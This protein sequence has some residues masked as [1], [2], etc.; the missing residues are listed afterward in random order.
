MNFTIGACRITFSLFFFAL[1]AVLL[2]FDSSGMVA[3]GLAAAALHEVSHLGAMYAFG[4]MPERINFN[5]FGI[6]IVR[7]SRPDHGYQ[8]DAAVSLA[9]PAANLLA[10]GLFSVLPWPMAQNL[11]LADWTLFLFNILP[12]E[13]LDGGQALYALLC[14]RWEP[15]TAA[16][17]VEIISFLVLLP[18]SAAGFWVLFRSPGNF[19]LLMVC[20]YLMFLLLFKKGKYF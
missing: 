20:C 5:M 18:L 16:Q 10:A 17:T 15:D 19:T 6:D 7:T 3:A 11:V 4:C 9:G 1:V 13:P 8:R 12:I 14:I 2:L